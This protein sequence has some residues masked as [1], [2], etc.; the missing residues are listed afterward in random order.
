MPQ[1]D[2]KGH[3]SA[4]TDALEKAAK[5]D[6]QILRVQQEVPE[7]KTLAEVVHLPEESDDKNGY[8]EDGKAKLQAIK[9]VFF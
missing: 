8:I 2:T 5:I 3:H 1:T 7:E 6:A 4:E 9:D